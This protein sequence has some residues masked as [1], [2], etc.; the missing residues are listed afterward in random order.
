MLYEVITNQ[1]IEH[2]NHMEGAREST[3][4]AIEN[5]SAVL[6]EIAA[7]S[8]NVNQISGDQLRS[9]ETLNQSAGNLNHNSE[10]V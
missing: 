6:E 10:L 2:A 7:S 8:N 4:G 5:M 9:V 1:V 3:L